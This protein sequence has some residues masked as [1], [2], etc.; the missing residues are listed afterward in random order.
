[1]YKKGNLTKYTEKC[2]NIRKYYEQ[3]YANLNLKE[4]HF[5]GKYK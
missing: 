5:S 1:M 4:R 2:K 3:V